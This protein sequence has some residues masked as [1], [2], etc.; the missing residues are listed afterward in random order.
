MGGIAC[1]ENTSLAVAIGKSHADAESGG[2][3]Q[4][5]NLRLVGQ[6]V[7]RHRLNMRELWPAGLRLDAH[8]R[9]RRLH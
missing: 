5:A 1:D 9:C 2:P 7:L 6:N 4:I 3:A 8:D